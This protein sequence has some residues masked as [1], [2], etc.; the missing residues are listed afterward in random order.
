MNISGMLPDTRMSAPVDDLLAD[1]ASRGVRLW[2]DGDRIRYDAPRT[3]MTPELIS[4]IRL[5][6]NELLVAVGQSATAAARPL[7]RPRLRRLTAPTD[8][9]AIFLLPPAGTG[10]RVFDG[11]R[12]AADSVELVA[13]HT[14]GR[15]ELLDER[16]YTDAAALADAIAG[17]IMGY[18]DRQRVIVGH[19]VG[20]LVGREVVKRL[21][22]TS[23]RLLVVAAAVPPDR[24]TD[25][26]LQV[27]D[28]DLLDA[29]RHFAGGPVD[30]TPDPA[31]L[32]PFLPV[33][34]ADLAVF[35]SCR[36][37]W[38]PG[39]RLDVP[40]LG[41]FGTADAEVTEADREAWHRW[42]TGA[43]RIRMFAGDHFFPLDRGA[44]LIAEIQHLIDG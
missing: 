35:E 44:E 40:V 1:L 11:W 14:P 5:H 26:H 37:T 38:T 13:V 17:E 34:R 36:T 18:G 4:R 8:G 15:E 33:F 3:A 42:T 27:T 32:A 29:M 41:A 2:A 9:P 28:D 23:V 30:A 16:P 39:E 10:P 25:D 6:R 7:G 22:P 31:S 12:T 43:F 19:S 20:A 24:L 21:P